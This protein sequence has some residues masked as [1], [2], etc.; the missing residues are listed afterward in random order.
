M[1]IK[2]KKPCPLIHANIFMIV[3]VAIK[4]LNQIMGIVVFSAHMVM[5]NVHRYSKGVHAANKAYIKN[6]L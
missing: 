2:K 6:I 1:A 5:L 3:K 4:C